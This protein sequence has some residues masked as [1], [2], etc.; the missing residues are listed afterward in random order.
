M[1]KCSLVGV[2][3]RRRDVR[4]SASLRVLGTLSR[5]RTCVSAGVEAMEE[6]AESLDGVMVWCERER[7]V[8]SSCSWV[9]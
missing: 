4:R 7:D 8:A 3:T 6:M 1:P 9:W 2:Y 5:K